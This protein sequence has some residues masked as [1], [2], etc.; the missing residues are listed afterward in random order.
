MALEIRDLHIEIGAAV[1]VERVSLDV[2]AGAI[3]CLLGASGSG[4]TLTSLATI[5][6]LPTTAE[7]SGSIKLSGVERD[8]L[9][10]DDAAWTTVRGSRIGHVGQNAL[11][12]LHPAFRVGWQ[13]A[14][15]IRR[16]ARISRRDVHERVLAEL[17]AVDL[18]D[19]ERVARARPAQ[20]SGGMCQRVALAIALCNRPQVLVADEP[21]T[22]LDH[23]TQDRVLN[24]IRRR[25]DEDGLGV[26]MITHDQT[27]VEQVADRVTTIADGRS[28]ATTAAA[29]VVTPIRIVGERRVSPE[30]SSAGAAAV[31][32]VAPSLEIAGVGKV[33]GPKRRNGQG[34]HRVLSDVDIT[35]ASGTTVGLVGRSGSGKSTL[36]KIVVG[37][38]DP[39]EGSVHVDGRPMTGPGRVGRLERAA[40][41]QYVFQDPFGSLN[42]RRPVREQVAEPLV[43]SGVDR[44]EAD[45]RASRMLADVGLSPAQ[46]ARPPTT[47]SGGQCQRVGVARALIR[48]PKLVVLDEPTSA[49]DWDIREGILELLDDLQREIGASYLLIS[50]ERP[51]IE[52]MSDVIHRISDGH[53]AEDTSERGRR[54]SL[55]P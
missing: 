9:D 53:V 28:S 48:R 54:S 45:D 29:D 35:A 4:K 31:S 5:G 33:F 22:A 34:A 37:V 19:V 3:H 42:P 46:I 15:A 44:A 38:L 36:A 20:L 12:C 6:L 51:L 11:G 30:P 55:A 13:I 7:P 17:T 2:E 32:P 43:A 39:T 52:R 40:L 41:A 21:T 50:H 25:V 24:L 23:E 18:S 1:P 47:L 14:E 26:L 27:V 49:L 16:H 10:F 8:L